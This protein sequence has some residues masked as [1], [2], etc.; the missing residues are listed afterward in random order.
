MIGLLDFF[1]GLIQGIDWS[2]VPQ[3]IINAISDFFNGFDYSGVF[4]K[5]GELIG[6]AVA[7]SIDLLK[8]LKDVLSKAWDKVVDYFSG[9]IEDSGGNIIEGL[10]NGIVDAIKG[11]GNWIKKNIFDPFI[12]GFKSAFGIHSPSK[13]LAEQGSYIISGLLKGLEDNISSVLDWLKNIPE[14]FKE[15]FSDAYKAAKDAFSNIGK[16]FGERW[17][18][19]KSVFT[20]GDG[21]TGWFKS[22]FDGAYKKVTSAF[23]DIGTWFSD[24][25]DDIKD[26]F[27]IGNGVS[28]WFKS[29][30]DGAYGKV[31]SAFSDVSKFF[32]NVWKNIKSPFSNIA[33]WFE[34]KFSKAWEAVKKVFSTGGKVFTGIKEGI[35]SG[36]KAV[37]NGLIGGINKVVAIPF[38][39][40]NA[41]LKKLKSISIAGMKPF[42]WLETTTVPQIPKLANGAVIRGGDPFMAVLGDQ[43]RGQTNIEAPLDTIKRANKAAVLEALSELG[44]TAGSSRNS[45]NEA[46]VFQVDGKTFFEITR[47]EAQQYFGRT[48][49]SPFPI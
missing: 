43:P 29:K 37:I 19:I 16:W 10:F 32:E 9:Y 47:R 23:S 30:F 12:K 39:G 14:W 15:K 1:I 35:L 21:I 42:D 36:L 17:E 7:A 33:S 11:I 40:I 44:V 6:T 48:G 28:G 31:T 8:A 18:D 26:V 49:R 2:G 27:T 5:I 34:D 22:K 38:N 13:V 41:A 25:W 20:S 46:F 3:G 4:G 45:G 24:R